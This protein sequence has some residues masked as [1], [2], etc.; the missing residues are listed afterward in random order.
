MD[1]F[2]SSRVRLFPSALRQEVILSVPRVNAGIISQVGL[3][4]FL[5]PHLNSKTHIYS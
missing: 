5:L 3:E 4:S 2:C 1:A